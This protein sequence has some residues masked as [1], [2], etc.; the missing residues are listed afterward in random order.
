MGTGGS[1]SGGK[2]AG[3]EADHTPP[4]S[5]EVKYVWIY[6]SIPQ[7]AIIAWW[8]FKE[9]STGTPR[10]TSDYLHV[11]LE[12]TAL[13]NWSMIPNFLIL[14]RWISH[15][16]I[17][18]DLNLGYLTTSRDSSVGMATRIRAVRSGF[19]GSIPG[20]G[21]EFF[22]SSSRPERLRGPPS[23]LSNGYQGLLPW[24]ES[25]RGVNWPLISI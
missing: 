11:H 14:L 18:G 12:V 10:I 7:Y 25:G 17:Y 9:E 13:S 20:R 22:S 3:R 2:A 4:F 5:A 21:W 8:S 19:Y 6:T 16:T 15:V 1:F 24:G 23:L